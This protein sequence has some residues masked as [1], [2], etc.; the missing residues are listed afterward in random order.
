MMEDNL[1][2]PFA[3]ATSAAERVRTAVVSKD[4]S[5]VSATSASFDSKWA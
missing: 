1:E 5:T 3:S 4:V 2:P